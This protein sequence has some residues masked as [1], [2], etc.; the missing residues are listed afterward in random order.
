MWTHRK[1]VPPGY[2]I[3]HIDHN[4]L[5]DYPD[6][7]QL[8]SDTDSHRQG[9]HLQGW[10]A[11]VSFFDYI[12]FTGEEPPEDWDERPMAKRQQNPDKE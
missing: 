11:A 6:N 7:L 4:S 2:V 5:N 1:V 3:D 10:D 9:A 8:Q 12:A